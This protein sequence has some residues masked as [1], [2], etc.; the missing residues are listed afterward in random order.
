M[1]CK[2]CSHQGWADLW[3]SLLK[4]NLESEQAVDSVYYKEIGGNNICI[5]HHTILGTKIFFKNKRN[6]KSEKLHTQITSG[7]NTV[8]GRSCWQLSHWAHSAISSERLRRIRHPL[9]FHRTAREGRPDSLLAHLCQADDLSLLP[10]TKGIPLR[11]CFA[12]RIWEGV[13][14]SS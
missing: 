1:A 12:M 4:N 2:P 13:Q 6:N 5:G 7:T 14:I 9:L 8:T 3:Q 11:K 10:G